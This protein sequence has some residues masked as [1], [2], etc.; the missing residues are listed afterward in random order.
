MN[1]QRAFD[2]MQRAFQRMSRAFSFASEQ[3][4]SRTEFD[5]RTAELLDEDEDDLTGWW[6]V[7]TDPFPCPAE[8]CDFV[9]LH[10]TAAH[11]I[12]VWPDLDDHDLL[13]YAND[14]KRVGRNPHIVEYEHSMGPCIPFD[15]WVSN[16]KLIHGVLPTPPGFREG[17]RRL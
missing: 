3:M 14:A 10:M 4:L 8:G 13:T 17:R 6:C 2:D 16:G 15:V 5:A 11:R 9:A 12:V 1:S 7:S